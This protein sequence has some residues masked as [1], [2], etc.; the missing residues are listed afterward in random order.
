[1]Q[2]SSLPL[3]IIIVGIGDAEFDGT[4]TICVIEF[5]SRT[6]AIYSNLASIL[7][8]NVTDEELGRA[9]LSSA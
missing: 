7:A 3:S 5:D 4:L 6:V 2:A 1:M 8:F 9:S